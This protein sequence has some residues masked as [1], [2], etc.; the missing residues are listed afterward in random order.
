MEV[1]VLQEFDIRQLEI[2]ELLR[3]AD[4]FIELKDKQE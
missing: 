1:S 4:D 2:C 3:S